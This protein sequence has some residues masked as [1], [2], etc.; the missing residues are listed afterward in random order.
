MN[1]KTTPNSTYRIVNIYNTVYQFIFISHSQ[2]QQLEID[3]S[4]KKKKKAFIA[5]LY[6]LGI[7]AIYFAVAYL[8]Q[9]AEKINGPVQAIINSAPIAQPVDIPHSGI[10]T[11]DL[12][13]TVQTN[14]VRNIQLQDHSVKQQ[15]TDQQKIKN[16]K[17]QPSQ[18]ENDSEFDMIE[19][20]AMDEFK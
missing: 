8:Q 9:K 1:T 10:K 5:A 15:S 4:T 11:D 20:A 16:V 2:P 12:N 3:P 13:K 6:V 14:E 18:E 17:K 19:A 7:T